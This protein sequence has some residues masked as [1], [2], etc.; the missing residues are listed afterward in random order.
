MQGNEDF[1][2]FGTNGTPD[3]NPTVINGMPI[4]VVSHA[5]TRG[6]N[7][8]SEWNHHIVEVVQKAREQLFC[9]SQLKRA[10][11]GPNE[12]VQFHHTCTRPIAECACPVF[13]MVYLYTFLPS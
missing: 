9:L 11:L 3:L 7:V 12:S 5:K 8:S 4:D 13:I 10:G 2:F 6:V 1:S